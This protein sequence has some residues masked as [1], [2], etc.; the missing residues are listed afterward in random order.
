VAEVW[1]GVAALSGL[2]EGV[3]GVSDGGGG[4]ASG[5]ADS[6]VMLADDGSGGTA[7]G[8]FIG[9]VDCNATTLSATDADDGLPPLLPGDDAGSAARLELLADVLLE[10][11]LLAAVPVAVVGAA[12]ESMMTALLIR[13]KPMVVTLS[14]SLVLR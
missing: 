6:C 14:P 3:G 8:R 10:M 4:E 1:R 12:P 5:G 7:I 2:I 13:A 9:N 11:V